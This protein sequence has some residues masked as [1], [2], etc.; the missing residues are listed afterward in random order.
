MKNSGIVSFIIS[1]FVFVSVL[2]QTEQKQQVEYPLGVLPSEACGVWCWYSTGG[3]PNKW[4][5]K[6]SAEE[7]YPQMRGVPIVV[8]WNELEPQDGVYNWDLVDDII[9]K[10]AAHDKYVFTLLWLNP[11]N[12]EWLYDKGVPKVEINSFK[13]DPHFATL[14]YPFDEKYKY[15]SERMIKNFADHIRSLPPELFRRV[16]FHQAVE[17]S[18]GD[19]FCYKGKPKDPKYEISRED[20][21]EYSQY[22]RKFTINAFQDTSDGKPP[23][24]LLIHTQDVALGAQMCEGLVVKQGFASHWYHPNGSKS[25]LKPFKPFNTDDNI[26]NRPVFCR[27]EGEVWRPSKKWLQENDAQYTFPDEGRKKWFQKDSLQNIYWSAL[28]AAHCGLDIW[29]LPEFVLESSQWYKALDMF[30]KYAGEKYPQR[31]PVAFCALKDDLNA[32]DKVRFPED[33]YGA[34]NK[35]NKDRVMKIC[36]E[37]AD[38]GAIIEDLDA[39]LGGGM[40]SRR[41]TGY[42]DV[43]WDRIEDDYCRYLYAIDKLETSVGWWHVGSPDEAYGRFARGFEHKTAKDTLFFKLHDRFFEQYPAGK[44]SV[45]VVWFDNNSGSWKLVYDAGTEIKT[46]FSVKGKNTGK[47]QEKTITITDAVM[48]HNGPR[49]SDI[50]LVNTDDK[51]DIFH[52]IE[53][54]RE[55][56]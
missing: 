23:V 44:L 34:A 1:L 19:G 2:A 47:W 51:D 39:S 28:Y 7:T 38:H 12:A 32:D 27:G 36:A 6:I 48:K 8:G 13:T 37:Y 29:S 42:N 9:K 21:A 17:G 15:Y 30:D 4:T 16:L 26:L 22:I 49:G 31:S 20:W 52:I 10:A 56:P 5:G 14:P 41:R 18:T 45:R 35:K 55:I 40:V 33:K 25:K 46:A 53:I 11:V 54:S 24:A 3:S 43:G 50:A